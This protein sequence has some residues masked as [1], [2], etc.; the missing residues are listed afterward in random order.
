MQLKE[1]NNQK[2]FFK[3]ALFF[4]SLA[5]AVYWGG[6]IWHTGKIFPQ[7]K[8]PYF[9]YYAK[10]LLDGHLYFT[11]IPPALADLSF[12]QNK[13]Y[14]HF[15]PFP[16]LLLIPLVKIFGLGLSGRFICVLLAAIN[17]VLFFKLLQELN[18]KQLVEV[19]LELM[20]GMTIFFLFGTVH[21]YCAITSNPW[22]FAHIVCNFLILL[23]LL[24]T[25]YR[26]YYLTAIL[27]VA[28]LFT[29]THIFLSAPVVIA[30]Y[31]YLEHREKKSWQDIFK[32]GIKYLLIMVAGVILLFVFNYARYG[33][34]LE[35]GITYHKMHPLFRE[36]FLEYGYFDLAYLGRNLKSLLWQS[37]LLINK[38]PF[39]TFTPK[40][41]SIFLA[42]PLYL[43]LLVSLRKK[44]IKFKALLWSGILLALIPILLLMGTGEFQFGHRYS[45][46]LQVFLCLLVIF[47]LRFKITKT[48][49]YLIIFSVLMN[50]YGAFWFVSRFAN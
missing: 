45:S 2:F 35:N 23:S 42:S 31:F 18:R 27:Y 13:V 43:Y 37:P 38:F 25:L 34:I 4:F 14:M 1:I 10:S 30:L 26:K 16:A 15:P 11:N 28:V 20:A 17:G 39:F 33:N 47:G 50:I 40:G 5:L 44:N 49:L 29:R 46:D 7:S 32:E 48:A 41:L 12:F 22:E 6:L 9:V 3:Y 24:T 8:W 36:R 21:F 19:S